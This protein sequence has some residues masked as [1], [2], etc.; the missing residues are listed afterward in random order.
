[1][2]PDE[3]RAALRQAEAELADVRREMDEYV[4]V[5]G[6]M[7]EPVAVAFAARLEA[8]NSRVWEMKA[9]LRTP[10]PR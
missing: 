5:H 8:A 2:T 7:P 6:C 3:I 4:E 1:M 10:V 9:A